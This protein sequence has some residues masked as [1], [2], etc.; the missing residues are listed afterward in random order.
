MLQDLWLFDPI[1]NAHSTSQLDTVKRF[2]FGWERSVMQD[3]LP[4]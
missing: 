2:K 1:L 4:E 3:T